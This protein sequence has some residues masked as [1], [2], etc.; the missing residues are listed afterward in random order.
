MLKG[1]GKEALAAA[2]LE[3]LRYSVSIL[4]VDVCIER[5]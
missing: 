5:T 4:Y 2:V 1:G 3:T